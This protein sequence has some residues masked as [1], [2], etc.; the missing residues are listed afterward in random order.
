M[1]DADQPGGLDGDPGDVK[2]EALAWV[3]GSPFWF[4][5]DDREDQHFQQTGGDGGNMTP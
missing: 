3:P 1:I 5:F 2:T 4:A